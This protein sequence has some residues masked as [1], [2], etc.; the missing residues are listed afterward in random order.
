M[1]TNTSLADDS[2]LLL[3]FLIC[4][5]FG[6]F[7]RL[8]LTLLNDF[9]L[10]RGRSSFASNRIRS[11]RNFFLNRDDVRDRLE[12]KDSGFGRLTTVRHAAVMSETLP[13]W[14]RPS[15]PLGTHEARWP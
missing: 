11:R 4:R 15:V 2:R 7:I 10:G 8:L 14:A 6:I 13:H 3:L 9:R 1:R 5:S 12:E